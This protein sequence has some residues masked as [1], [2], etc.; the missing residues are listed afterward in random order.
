MIEMQNENEDIDSARNRSQAFSKKSNFNSGK[1]A[2][3]KPEFQFYH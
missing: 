3:K 1:V 2:K